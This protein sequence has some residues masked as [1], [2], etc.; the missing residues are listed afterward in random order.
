MK[1]LKN[2]YMITFSGILNFS[3]YHLQQL[4]LCQPQHQF[5]VHRLHA[6]GKLINDIYL[7]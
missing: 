2:L 5:L 1:S 6:T 7:E 4:Q 3:W